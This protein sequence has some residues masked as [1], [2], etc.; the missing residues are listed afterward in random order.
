M[1]LDNKSLFGT[2]D[3]DT[4]QVRYENSTHGRRLPRDFELDEDC[5]NKSELDYKMVELENMSVDEFE[6]WLRCRIELKV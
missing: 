2:E 1:K 4:V 6:K 5:D 3:I